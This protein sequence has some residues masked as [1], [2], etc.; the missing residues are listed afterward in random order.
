MLRSGQSVTAAKGKTHFFCWS[1]G[2]KLRCVL[3]ESCAVV[4]PQSDAPKR[5]P[6]WSCS[7]AQPTAEPA[8]RL[9]PSNL[10]IISCLL[11][12]GCSWMQCFHL[13]PFSLGEPTWGVPTRDGSRWARGLLAAWELWR[14]SSPSVKA[15][16]E[17]AGKGAGS[18]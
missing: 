9:R 2:P 12:T 16:W 7:P 3:R 5:C 18:F 4:L 14:S 8:V 6:P 13:H 11:P 17:T 1:Q 10:P 15:L